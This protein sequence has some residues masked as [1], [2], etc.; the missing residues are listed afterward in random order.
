MNKNKN[1][2]TRNNPSVALLYIFT[3]FIFIKINYKLLTNIIIISTF[4][5]IKY[6]YL[7]R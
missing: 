5:K 2:R 6:I 4:K 1:T 3:H 7:Y